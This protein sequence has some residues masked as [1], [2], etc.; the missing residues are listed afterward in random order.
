M[1]DDV[2][3]FEATMAELESIAGSLEGEDLELDEALAL[4]ERGVRRLREA[5]RLLDAANGRVEELIE[6]AEGY[7]E[8][9]PVRAEEEVDGEAPTGE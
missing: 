4:F 8:L 5:A 6:E 1:T 7:W 2:R 3:S 9:H